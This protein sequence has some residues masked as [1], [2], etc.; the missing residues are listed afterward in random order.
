MVD[1]IFIDDVFC[2]GELSSRAHLPL[3]FYSTELPSLCLGGMSKSPEPHRLRKL[4]ALV[5]NGWD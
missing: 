5:W 4:L 2:I 3:G 1:I